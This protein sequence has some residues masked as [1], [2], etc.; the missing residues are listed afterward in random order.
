MDGKFD[1]LESDAGHKVLVTGAKGFVGGRLVEFLSGRGYS[2]RGSTREQ[3]E[4]PGQDYVSVGGLSA[5]TD[6]S[7]ALAGVDYVVH[8]AG[9]AH[10]PPGDVS[11]DRYYEVNAAGTEAL[12]RAAL[13][14][15]VRRFVFV[16]SIKA[17]GEQSSQGKPFDVETQPQPMDAYGASKLDAEKRLAAVC[18]DSAMEYV[19]IRPPLIYGPG[20]RANFE[21]MMN[22][23][24]KGL[25]LPL[26]SVNNRRSILFLDN[27]CDLIALSLQ[28]PRVNNRVLLP[29]DE[30]D[31]STPELI[32]LIAEALH[33]RPPLFPFPVALL[34]LLAV[35]TGRRALVTRLLGSLQMKD[36]HLRDTVNWRPPFTTQE[37][38][39]RTVNALSGDE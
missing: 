31:C 10:V 4:T 16:S 20:V 29:T 28:H 17:F 37:G 32:S 12:A 23:V 33:R 22:A 36:T 38:I 27:L 19:I 21:T 9:I 25:P 26:G 34:K 5:T 15:A 6:W 18:A 1:S 3:C 2:V 11:A 39:T 35:A 13:E 7:A 14:H 24:R 8:L 30:R